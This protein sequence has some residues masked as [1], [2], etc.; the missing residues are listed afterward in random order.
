MGKR[1]YENEK[2]L[3]SYFFMPGDEVILFEPEIDEAMV[4]QPDRIGDAAQIVLIEGAVQL[5]PE[6]V[7]GVARG[8]LNLVARTGRQRLEQGVAN[9][10]RRVGELIEAETELLLWQDDQHTLLEFEDEFEPAQKRRSQINDQDDDVKARNMIDPQK[11]VDILSELIPSGMSVVT[12]GGHTVPRDSDQTVLPMQQHISCIAKFQKHDVGHGST[13]VSE[14]YALIG[15]FNVFNVMNSETATRTPI[16]GHATDW[17]HEAS[18]YFIINDEGSSPSVS[19]VRQWDAP[20]IMR[21]HK[22]E[23]IYDRY[24]VTSV[25]MVVIFTNV[26]T[27]NTIKVWGRF[28]HQGDNRVRS[29]FAADSFGWPADPESLRALKLET[30]GSEVYNSLSRIAVDRL[31]GTPGMHVL[32]LGPNSANGPPNQQMMVFEVPCASLARSMSPTLLYTAPAAGHLV[33]SA[34]AESWNTFRPDDIVTLHDNF[35]QGHIW[36][37]AAEIEDSNSGP[38]IGKIKPIFG[39]DTAGSNLYVEGTAE[40]KVHLFQARN[41]AAVGK[42]DDM[43]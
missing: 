30:V 2:F 15:G 42:A 39:G 28:F 16:A 19:Q 40:Y 23:A 37:W 6:S 10:A 1:A 25:K 13:G 14:N 11:F 20:Q 33:E 24:H 27:V 31:D 38:A 12:A 32:T 5:V 17:L 7:R 34:E 3:I 18:S 41:P 26:D 4:P 43:A 35:Q 29:A 8:I 36:F 9:L 21:L 22:A